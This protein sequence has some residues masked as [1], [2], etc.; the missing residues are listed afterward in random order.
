MKFKSLKLIGLL[1]CG[2]FLLPACDKSTEE[3]LRSL[4]EEMDRLEQEDLSIRNH[5]LGRINSLRQKLTD[6]I[7]EVEAEL[8]ARIDEEGE[9]LIR[10]LNLKIMNLKNKIQKGF[11][12]SR[13]YM[14]TSFSSCKSDISQTFT[15][16]DKSKDALDKEIQKA[17]NAQQ[18]AK[19]KQLM[20]VE[21]KL[22]AVT[23]RAGD[24]ENAIK[25]LE[26]KLAN[27]EEFKRKLT[28]IA[29]IADDLD[30]AYAE[31]ERKQLQLMKL[32]KEDITEDYLASLTTAQLARM[33][34][35]IASAETLINHMESYKGDLADFAAGSD[36]L[37]SQMLNLSDDFEDALNAYEDMADECQ[38]A[39][40]NVMDIWSWFDN[41]EAEEHL[42]NIMDLAGSNQELYDAAISKLD[43]LQGH[44]D[45]YNSVVEEWHSSAHDY[46]ES[47]YDYA[48]AALANYEE[49]ESAR[50]Y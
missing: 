7:A 24:V 47:C 44:L 39:M 14:N 18:S 19:V 42:S 43:E 45:D 32:V 3:E 31:M 38:T 29:V 27:A 16:L 21:R 8:N 15:Y 50:G 20:E 1:L 41:S 2:I 23:K 25:G 5:F 36:D 13:E 9:G 6:L 33:K 37:L 28:N 26:G 22:D 48:D 35:A 10:S 17:I 11:S 34:A 4:E 46:F 40:D 12:E 49:I 30:E